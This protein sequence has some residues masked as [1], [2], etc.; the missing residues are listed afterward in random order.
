MAQLGIP[1]SPL[2][3]ASQKLHHKY[4]KE[5]PRRSVSTQGI[6]ASQKLHHK[7]AK[8]EPRQRSVSTHGTDNMKADD[9]WSFYPDMI[10]A[11]TRKPPKRLLPS[12]KRKGE[13]VHFVF[14]ED[15][16]AITNHRTLEAPDNTTIVGRH[17]VF[18]NPAVRFRAS[19]P[20]V[21]PFLEAMKRFKP[22]EAGKA[23]KAQRDTRRRQLLAFF[24]K[25]PIP[26]IDI[27]VSQ[28]DRQ[29]KSIRQTL[30][31][32]SWCIAVFNEAAPST[33]M[34]PIIY[35]APEL[36]PDERVKYGMLRKLAPVAPPIELRLRDIFSLNHVR[37]AVFRT[38]HGET[39]GG[40]FVTPVNPIPLGGP[41]AEQPKAQVSLKSEPF[42]TF[43]V[44]QFDIEEEKE[45]E[46]EIEMQHVHQ[47]LRVRTMKS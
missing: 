14:V 34:R 46:V 27:Y 40:A 20:E 8:E 22:L 36:P 1:G 42:R 33:G 31:P 3:H 30:L 7:H 16:D 24:A 4:V 19:G 21:K 26:T 45:K 18:R 41:Q 47:V 9:L 13:H 10:G 43:R 38:D 12:R 37:D 6:D 17:R 2:F 11:R 5:E 32:G 25:V 39:G 29:Y 35:G 28:H 44:E 23:T 15:V